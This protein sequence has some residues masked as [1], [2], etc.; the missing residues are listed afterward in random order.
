[1]PALLAFCLSL[2]GC[3]GGGGGSTLA[4]GGGIGGTGI[5]FGRITGFGSVI[6]NGT[7]FNTDNA[8][9][10]VNGQASTQAQLSEGML[11]RVEGSWG[12][13]G[14]GVAERVS[15]ADDIR[16]PVQQVVSFDPLTGAGEIR[17]LG[18]TV[19][20]DAQTVFRGVGRDA[21]AVDQL[22]RVSGWRQQDGAMLASLVQSLGDFSD[23]GEVELKGFISDLDTGARRFRIAGVEIDYSG[24]EIEM[25]GDRDN[26]VTGDEGAFVEVEGRFQGGVLLADEVEEEDE[27]NRFGA[28]AGDDVELEGP[29]S[30][31]DAAA[32]TFVVY[33]VTV[34]VTNRTEFD[35]GLREGDLQ[36]GLLVEVE[37]EW[38][39]SGELVAE[40]IEARN[41]DAEVQ[42]R[43]EAIDTATRLLRVGGVAVQVSARTL[44]MDDDDD[45]DDERLAFEDLRQ[46]DYL[47]VDGIRRAD[48]GGVVS[49][50]ALRIERDDDDDDGFQLKGRVD[51]IDANAFEVLGVVL[52]VDGGTEWDDGLDDFDDLRVGHLVEVEYEQR[53]GV[54]YALEVERD[55]D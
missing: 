40:E 33:G 34:R 47:E 14:Q 19:R 3:L 2:T 26:I 53:G 36:P 51:R 13:D 43:L 29:I 4:D 23:G 45:D 25:R 55:D 11:V 16:G 30:S 39:A 17:V 35:D 54:Y 37:G 22:L 38:N 24:A 44:I 49:L 8:E 12:G 5:S 27:G 20:F 46:G 48:A 32:R 1:L 10:L 28:R 7:R 9:I 6:V 21:L 15:Y 42:A 31:V 50:E 41:A 52:N 18:Q